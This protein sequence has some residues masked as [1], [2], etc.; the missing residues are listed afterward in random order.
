MGLGPKGFAAWLCDLAEVL[1][2]GKRQ[3][4]LH[5]YTEAA[6]FSRRKFR[7]LKPKGFDLKPDPSDDVE[8][9]FHF[10]GSFSTPP[11]CDSVQPSVH[12]IS[13]NNPR[14]AMLCMARADVLVTSRSSLSWASAVLSEGPVFH[15]KAERP[16]LHHW[17]LRDQYLDW[18]ENWFY[19]EDVRPGAPRRD[20]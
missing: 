14:E 11:T 4:Q 3:L 18:A 15:P 2:V 1:G 12:F 16:G 6:G 5:L 9:I 8:P 7:R 13:N 10:N 19:L 20:S 17:D